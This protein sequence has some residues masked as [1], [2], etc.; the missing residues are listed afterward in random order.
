MHSKVKLKEKHNLTMTCVGLACAES[1]IG[2]AIFTMLD[3]KTSYDR[4]Q[5]LNVAL[6]A[7]FIVILTTMQNKICIV[8]K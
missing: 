4:W 7:I 3:S 2:V 6:F 5:F 1:T 8:L